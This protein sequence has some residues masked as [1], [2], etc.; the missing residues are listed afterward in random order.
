MPV[1][2]LAYS[3]SM[4]SLVHYRHLHEWVKRRTADFQRLPGDIVG[5]PPLCDV[6]SLAGQIEE[7]IQDQGL[8]S[9]TPIRL[10]WLEA[11]GTELSRVEV[12][13][14]AETERIRS[15]AVRLS[16]TRRLEVPTIEIIPYIDGTPAGT[17]RQADVLWLGECLYVKPLAKAKL[18]RC[19]PEE[20]ARAFGRPEIKAALDYSFERSA[21]IVTDYMR[22]NFSLRSALVPS[23]ADSSAPG[24]D[25]ATV[26]SESPIGPESRGN[27]S[28]EKLGPESDGFVQGEPATLSTQDDQKQAPIVDISDAAPHVHGRPRPAVPSIMERF[29]KSQGLRADGEARFY[30]KDGS[31][32]SKAHGVPFPW[33]R[34]A[35]S[36]DLMCRYWAKEHCL[37]QEALQL[38]S[39]IWAQ[40][41]KQPE[42]HSLILSDATGCPIEVSGT[43]LR[44]MRDEGRITLYPASYRLVYTHDHD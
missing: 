16:K 4:Q 7:R 22:E 6:P 23:P 20:I 36:G 11:L 29:A 14:E 21:V 27:A 12:D 40:L 24:Q 9:C 25:D 44:K 13:S 43:R 30:H 37:E 10:D 18:A 31:W 5:K 39:E 2:E 26:D 17:P 33:E 19:I 28:G 41:D 35:S 15:L 3:L 8:P 1:E 32:I 42:L 38:D 34:F